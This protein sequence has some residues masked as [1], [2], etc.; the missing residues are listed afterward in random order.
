MTPIRTRM[1][2]DMQMRNLS[3]HTQRAYVSAVAR[4]STFF[5]KSPEQLGPEDVRTYLLHIVHKRRASWSFYNQTLCA[6]RFLYHT[7]LVRPHLLDGIPCPKKAKRAEIVVAVRHG[8]IVAAFVADEW[9]PATTENFP[10]HEPGPGRHGF[11]GADAS[12]TIQRMYIGKR[13]PDE[14]RKRGAANPIKYTYR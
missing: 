6:L 4:F 2:E 12:D 11:V 9:L 14:Y 13:L 1:I 8:M 5:R 10:G 7:T 3:P